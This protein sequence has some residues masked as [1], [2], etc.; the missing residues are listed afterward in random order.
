MYDYPNL[1]I[2]LRVS[3]STIH[4][5]YHFYHLYKIHLFFDK[6]TVGEA[7]T[8]Q[9]PPLTLGFLFLFLTNPSS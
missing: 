7:P 8:V 5:L 3:L 1:N 2:Y 6:G 4:L 9:D